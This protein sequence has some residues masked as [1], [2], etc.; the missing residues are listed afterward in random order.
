MLGSCTIFAYR[1]VQDE[2][3]GQDAQAQAQGDE[4]P[5]PVERDISTREADPEPLT[6]KEVF[7][8]KKIVINPEEPPYRVLRTQK[9]KD[10]TVAAADALGDLIEELGC[11][12]VVRATLRSPDKDY[13]I[14]GGIFNLKS[15]ADAERVYEQADAM[16]EE[17]TGRFL[18]LLAGDETQPILLSQTNAG[19]DYRGHFVIYLII[20]RADGEPLTGTDNGHSQVILYDIAEVHLRTNVLDG[21]AF[22]PAPGA[23]PD[24]GA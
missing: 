14:S 12:H 19:W 7:P 17:D 24:A 18:G 6:V 22:E 1:L 16:I 13:L 21:R 2:L 9:S 5:A 4:S 10:C 11:N 8:D 20:A 3:A 15:E 23:S